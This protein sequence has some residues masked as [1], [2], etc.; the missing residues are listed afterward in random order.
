MKIKNKTI[1]KIYNSLN[2]VWTF[3]AILTLLL[4]I[5]S[6][7][8]LSG[9]SI[10][11]Y[12]KIF[13]GD[14]SDSNL[15]AN[16]PQAIRSDEF[17]V[18]AQKYIAQSNN[19]YQATN[20]NIGNG[21]NQAVVSDNPTTDWSGI[22]KPQNFGFFFLPFDNAFSFK[23]WF[24]PYLLII[25]VYFT[26][27]VFLPKRY[28]LAST[29]ASAFALSPFLHWWYTNGTFSTISFALLGFVVLTKILSTKSIKGTVLWSLLLV[30]IAASFALVLYPPFQIPVALVV[31]AVSAG[32]ITNFVK[33]E[34]IP[35]FKKKLLSVSIALLATL[36]IIGSFIYSHK[37]TVNA[38]Q[39]SAYPGARVVHSGG[40]S[41]E[42][43]LS[44]HLSPVFQAEARSNSYQRPNIS[45][46]NQSESSN[47]IL[48]I[49]FLI[50]PLVVLAFLLYKSRKKLDFITISLLA[51]GTVF[52]AWLFIP[53]IDLLGKLSLLDKVPHPRLLIGIGVLNL[54]FII[55]FIKLYTETKHR[56]DF[57]SSAIY[58]LL[59]YIALLIISFHV[60]IQFPGFIGLKS[61]VILPFII[62]LILFLLLRKHFLTGMF[63][64]LVFSLISVA[65]INPIYRGTEILT[66]TPLSQAMKEVGANSD[67]RWVTEDISILNFPSMNGL[68]SLSG[69]YL[70]PQVDLWEN[71]H[72]TE[73]SAVY[74]RYAHTNFSFDRNPNI[75]IAPVISNPGEDQ[76]NITIEPCD[77]FFRAEN[78]G[79]LVSSR[80]FE[81]NEASCL[82]LVR[83]VD[84]PQVT[85]NI[86]SYR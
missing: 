9:S 3:P 13:Y 30:Y 26:V 54:F 76:M 78:V 59:I 37:D 85:F 39:S 35:L 40:Y 29:I 51:I 8:S 82:S 15:I 50:A 32:Y 66:K 68:P 6:T 12:Q 69:T 65:M 75:N 57:K 17:V 25:A 47:F 44:S 23:W 16:K 5:L 62:P 7:L 21:E 41:K 20:Q 34:K 28:L 19:N 31:L 36:A 27:L 72:Q 43:I 83:S 61:V 52:A 67:K 22:F 73:K 1:A 38:V 53:G 58:S 81:P 42:H 64:Y 10:G 33:N 14:Q 80:K 2:S 24:M 45:A 18:N 77:P 46:V 11:Y 49:P 56:L 48:L 79:Y 74:N 71:L 4:V 86:Y 60:M 70:H 84:Y 55:Y 63:V